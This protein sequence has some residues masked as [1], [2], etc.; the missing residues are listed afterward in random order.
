MRTQY[1]K[2]IK[3]LQYDH[4]GEYLS[5]EFNSHLKAQGMIRSLMVHNTPEEN[6]VAE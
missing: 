3:I 4:G 1:G 6:G 2:W 5:K